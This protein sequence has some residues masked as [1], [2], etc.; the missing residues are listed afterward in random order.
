MPPLL[1]PCTAI[2]IHH[3]GGGGSAAQR[4]KG[5]RDA[6]AERKGGR[7]EVWAQK[8]VC[9]RRPN[10]VFPFVRF[11]LSHYEI[12]VQGGGVQGGSPPPVL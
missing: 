3:S 6:L 12:G 7:A 8:A 5:T 2:P 11:M 4:G 9:Q 10:S 1:L